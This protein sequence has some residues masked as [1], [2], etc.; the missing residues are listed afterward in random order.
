M[1]SKTI[2]IGVDVGGTNTDICA[3]DETSGALMVYKL[4]S[5]LYDQSEAVVSGV[6][7]IADENNFTGEEVSRFMHG[8]TVATNAILEGRGAKTALITTGGFR[9]LLEIGRQKRPDLYNLQADK[10]KTLISRDCRF[11]ISERINYEGNIVRNFDEDELIR[12]VEAMKAE[13]VKAAAVMLLNAYL[14]PENE[15]RIK[16]ILEEKCPDVFLTI[17]SDLSKQFREYERL[18]G[19]VINSFVGP[20]VRK[21]MD[22]LKSTLKSIGVEN[23]YINHSNGGLMSIDESMRYPVKT[24]LSGPAAGVVGAQYITELINEKDLITVDIGGTSTDISLVVDGRFEA[25]DEKTISGYPVRIPS[26]DISTIGAGGGSIAWIDSGGILKVGP[27]SAGASPGPACYKQGGEEATITDA[28]VVLGHLN[29][30]VLLGGRLPIEAA[31]SEAAIKRL[32]DRINMDLM[33]TAR[34]I[35]SISNSNIIKEIKNVT[36][37]KG[38]NP[39]EFC[40]AAFGGSGPLH[41]A[42]LIDEMM[43]KKALIPKTPGL[44]AAYGL[45]TENMRRDFVQTNVMEVSAQ[46]RDILEKQFALLEK[47]ADAWFDEEKIDPEKRSREYFLDMRYKGQ[48]HEIRVPIEKSIISSAEEIRKEFT[49]AYERLYSFSSDDAVQIVN[50]GLSAIGDIIYPVIHEEAYDGEDSWK[51]KT[52]SRKVYE[53]NGAY[54]DYDLYDREKLRNGN[55]VYG[56]AI[57]EQ[58]D[59]TTIIL[60]G[61]K[62]TVDQYLNMMIERV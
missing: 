14:N 19:T 2:R 57:V 24:A 35:I 48:N 16:K 26:I 49:S 46:C 1:G 33:E 7:V 5:S 40:L 30:Q 41:A 37:A 36:V 61:Q 28:R 12:I 54:S 23:T 20:E 27:Q 9:D 47:E 18:C 53:G 59:S 11:E 58:M 4:P 17:S 38:Y 25:S 44:L 50:F 42:E 10:V 8:T 56:P 43:I 6:K 52:G 45:L 34:G 55:V 62:A 3:I 32:A 13:D 60:K 39:S 31:L 15:R 21:Y 51:A 29:N 22:N